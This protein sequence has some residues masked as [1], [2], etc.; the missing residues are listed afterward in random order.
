MT[1][2]VLQIIHT[3]PEENSHL[4]YSFDTFK[5]Y[6][7]GHTCLYYA[8]GDR[9]HHLHNYM[10]IDRTVASACVLLKPE[11]TNLTFCFRYETYREARTLNEKVN[12]DAHYGTMFSKCG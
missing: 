5:N 11:I 1:D 9:S 12:T 8:Q 4:V 6:K 3:G 10:G 7:T 2:Y